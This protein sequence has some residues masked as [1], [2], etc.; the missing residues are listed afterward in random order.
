MTFR[1]RQKE[2]LQPRDDILVRSQHSSG[3]RVRRI[4]SR[5]SSS[6][7]ICSAELRI[8][9]WSCDLYTDCSSGSNSWVMSSLSRPLLTSTDLSLPFQW[10]WSRSYSCFWC[11]SRLRRVWD[12]RDHSSQACRVRSA[13]ASSH[14]HHQCSHIRGVWTGETSDTE[15][16][17]CDL[18]LL[19]SSLKLKPP[20]LQL[21]PSGGSA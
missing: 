13:S 11:C 21:R 3:R 17:F 2:R 7:N 12:S 9:N 4:F 15:S 19:L 10:I 1:L 20:Q 16:G 5:S 18:H 6:E 14:S 8:W